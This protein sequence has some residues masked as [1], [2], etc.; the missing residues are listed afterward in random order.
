MRDVTQSPAGYDKELKKVSEIA[1]KQLTLIIRDLDA[2]LFKQLWPDSVAQAEFEILKRL[3]ASVIFEKLIPYRT[4]D[5][6][7]VDD[8]VLDS[9]PL[10]P[11]LVYQFEDSQKCIFIPILFQSHFARIKSFDFVLLKKRD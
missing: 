8:L 9:L 5:P 2:N 10:R 1:Y 6:E 7:D 11:Q 4:L 3:I